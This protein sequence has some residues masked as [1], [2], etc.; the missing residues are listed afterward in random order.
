MGIKCSS[1]YPTYLRSDLSLVPRGSDRRGSTVWQ[2]SD[3]YPSLILLVETW[4]LEHF[5]LKPFNCRNTSINTN[6]ISV[7]INSLKVL[8]AYHFICQNPSK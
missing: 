6:L 3:L 8:N 4:Y 2:Y 7:L 5:G 1:D